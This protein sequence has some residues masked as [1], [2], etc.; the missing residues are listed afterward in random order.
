MQH[1][2]YML[3][4]HLLPNIIRLH[5]YNLIPMILHPWCWTSWKEGL[6]KKKNIYKHK[7]K[8]KISSHGLSIQMFYVLTCE[9]GV[10]V[11][12]GTKFSGICPPEIKNLMF[13]LV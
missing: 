12:F 11:W 9:P 13:I 2:T 8:T 6:Q 7:T 10:L 1:E 4:E 5:I 3:W